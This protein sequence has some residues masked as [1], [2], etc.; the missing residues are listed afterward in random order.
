VRPTVENVLF[1]QT[2]AIETFGGSEGVRDLES[3]RA[4]VARPWGSSFGQDH[5]STPFEKAA[6]LA[7]SLIRRHPFIDGNKRTAMYA[8]AYLLETFGYA[9]EVEQAELE[10][11][12][13]DVAQGTFESDEIATWFENHS[14]KS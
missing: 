2:V 5:F 3:L 11:F 9:L 1:L 14:R 8:A 12:A 7:E 4:A 13:V 6:A 10:D